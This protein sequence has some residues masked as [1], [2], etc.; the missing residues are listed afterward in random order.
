MKKKRGISWKT[1]GFAL[2]A[3]LAGAVLGYWGMSQVDALGLPGLLA[4]LLLLVLA[5]LLQVTVHEGGHLAGGL[6]TGYRP[7]F[8]RVGRIML[9]KLDGRWRVRAYHIP[10]TGG[11]C[12]M[13]PPD[14]EEPP[15]RL[16]HLGGGLANLL[17]AVLAV[18]VLLLTHAPLMR[19]FALALVLTGIWMAGTNL[20]PMQIGG[21]ANDGYNAKYLGR[22]PLALRCVSAQLRVNEGLLRGVALTD[23][24]ETWFVLPLGADLGNPMI[25]GTAMQG[26]ARQLER[27]DIAG[28][29]QAFRALLDRGD[30]LGLYRREITCEVIFCGLLL[31]RSRAEL[32]KLRSPELTRYEKATRRFFLCRVRQ[33]YA[34]AL[35][36]EG[37]REKARVL[38]TDFEKAASRYP[39]IGELAGER[40][41][42]DRVDRAARS[43]EKE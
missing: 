40:Q 10:G 39:Y 43:A 14:R 38:R 4:L 26:A 5:Y 8:F 17:L 11:Q 42:L 22:D 3:A 6:I 7:L 12:L 34:W 1:V 15:C 18:P 2:L 36:A 27:G 25:A 31:G 24:P 35:L 41:L 9:V 16:Y 30:L 29:D 20:F 37:D 23:M 33:A 21:M 28:A 19:V 13:A 32:E